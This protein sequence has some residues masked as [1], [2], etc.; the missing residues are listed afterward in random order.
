MTDRLFVGLTYDNIVRSFK[1]QVI[2]IMLW[3]ACIY[4]FIKTSCLNYINRD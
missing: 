3:H 4:I 1:L 2:S